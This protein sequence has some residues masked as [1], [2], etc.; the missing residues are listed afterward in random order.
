MR[1]LSPRPLLAAFL[2]GL[3][4]YH[5]ARPR[6]EP[7]PPPPAAP[8]PPLAVTASAFSAVVRAADAMVLRWGPAGA[9]PLLWTPVVDGRATLAGLLP[10][11][12]YVV[13]DGTHRIAFRTPAVPPAV[14]ARV[15]RGVLRVDGAPFFPL[16]TWQECPNAWA[17]ELAEGIDL[18]AGNPCTNL[19]SLVAGVAGR[20]LVAGTTADAAGTTGPGLIGW[21]YPDEADG[22]GFTGSTLPPPAGPGLRFLTLTAHFF[23]G[24]APLPEGRWM[25]PGLVRAADVVGFDLYPLQELCRPDLLPWVDDAQVAL[26][27]L[28]PR[29]ATFQWIEVREL[30][31]PGADAAVTPATIR[32]E[33]W[34]A[35]AGGANG[36]GF[37][38]ADWDAATGTVI[39]GIA[40]RIRQLLPALVQRPIPVAAA[41]A[42]R[43]SARALGG[44]LYL[45]VVNPGTAATTVTLRSPSLGGR[46]FER[47]GTARAGALTVRLPPRTVRIGVAPPVHSNG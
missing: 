27:R 6:P 45:I 26:R 44:A 28:A 37:F 18:F 41:G 20:A 38:P 21:F 13:D 31:C 25:Y 42:V 10:L 16:M 9:E 36:L 29:A 17:P 11:R 15:R 34:L 24:A 2:V 46:T 39:R 30:K 19:Q 43:A 3:F 5:P 32:V 14:T 7:P 8:A 1:A 33:S 35:I 40:G 23:A 4:A 22:N 47:L 12:R